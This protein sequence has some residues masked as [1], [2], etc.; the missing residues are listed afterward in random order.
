MKPTEPNQRFADLQ[1]QGFMKLGRKGNRKPKAIRPIIACDE[2][3]D[4]HREGEHTKHESH[5]TYLQGDAHCNHPLT[6]SESN[7]YDNHPQLARLCKRC[8]MEERAR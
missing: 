8:V 7:Y 1:K 4:W 6:E 5:S 2:C 3:H